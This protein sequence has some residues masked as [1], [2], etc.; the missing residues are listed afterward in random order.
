MDVYDAALSR[1][2]IRRFQQKP[3]PLETLK[4]VVNAARLAPSAANLQPLEFVAVT[5]KELCAKIFDTIG[6]AAY[7]KPRWRPGESERPV[8]YVII[9]FNTAIGAIKYSRHDIG[10]A[11]ENLML[12][13]EG[14][15]LG[16]CMLCSFNRDT[17]RALLNVPRVFEI[18]AM[19]ALGYK[20]ET[21][22]VED[23]VDSVEYWRDKAQV[24]HVPKRKLSDIF[25]I[26]SF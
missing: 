25:H 12:V 1:R 3:I 10:L 4:K 15:G 24:F 13:A 2:S 8:A 20:V 21:S 17:V 7:L 6:W 5:D 18:E 14:E 22:R 26:N 19:I 16:S 23:F 9:V 11:A